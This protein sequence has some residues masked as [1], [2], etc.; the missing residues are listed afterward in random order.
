M[1]R[2]HHVAV[3]RGD[4]DSEPC[5]I[6]KFEYCH[7]K[8]RLCRFR[9]KFGVFSPF[10]YIIAQN[11]KKIKISF[12]KNRPQVKEIKVFDLKKI[13]NYYVKL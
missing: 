11:I 3:I 2:V 1:V 9:G 4:V 12:E 10:L 13:Y 8:P 6:G 5:V 7:N